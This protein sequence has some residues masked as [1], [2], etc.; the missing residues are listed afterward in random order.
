MSKTRELFKAV[1]E[2]DT[3]YRAAIAAVKA[4]RA[5]DGEDA[6]YALVRACNRAERALSRAELLYDISKR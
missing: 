6:Y 3:A 5:S 2:C 4:H 1:V